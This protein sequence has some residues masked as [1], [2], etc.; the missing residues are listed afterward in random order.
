MNKALFTEA[1]WV[2][3][4]GVAVSA[5]V[6]IGIGTTMSVMEQRER[7]NNAHI[8]AAIMAHRPLRC[9]IDGKWQDFP[10]G[11]PHVIDATPRAVQV[12]TIAWRPHGC[13][14]S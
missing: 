4:K 7:A 9:M 10:E 5:V 14:A 12:R 8:A 13:T 3:V 11:L 6:Y 1:G 2:L